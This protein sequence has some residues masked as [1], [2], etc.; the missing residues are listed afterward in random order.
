[1]S[2]GQVEFTGSRPN[3]KAGEATDGDSIGVYSHGDVFIMDIIGEI[4]GG[5]APKGYSHAMYSEG[6]VR[7]RTQFYNKTVFTGNDGATNCDV[8]LNVNTLNYW[9]GNPESTD[10]VREMN[11]SGITPLENAAQY[12]YLYVVTDDH[13]MPTPFDD[14]PSG[15]FYVDP[16]LWAVENGITNGVDNLHFAPDQTC[17]RAQTVTF[18]WRANGSPE[19][20][21]TETPFTDINEKSYYYKAVLWAV[22]NGITNGMTPTTFEPDRTVT[23]GQ[24]VTF[25]WRNAGEPA[26]ECWE[27]D[28]TDVHNNSF[29]SVPV[30]WAVEKGIT[31]GMTPTTFVPDNGCTRGQI[32]TFLCRAEGA[33]TDPMQKLIG[34]WFVYFDKTYNDLLENVRVHS[35]RLSEDHTVVVD[36]AYPEGEYLSGY[37]GTWTATYLGNGR[38]ELLL[39]VRADQEKFS[40]EVNDREYQS[41]LKV[42]VKDNRMMVTVTEGS[43]TGAPRNLE[44]YEKDLTYDAWLEGEG[45][46]YH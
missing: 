12:K 41:K 9:A 20:T 11:V 22:E 1:M 17:N 24:V 21:V 31:T 36:S 18:L 6:R 25:L 43:S 27:N 26:T 35:F 39:T 42:N 37:E 32:V 29:F 3:F 10:P 8:S 46:N 2:N 30:Q 40:N 19:P 13:Y 23:R 15:K 38:Y 44:V 16:V 5:N 34:D 7:F 4:H 33:A 45:Q 28:F 14:V